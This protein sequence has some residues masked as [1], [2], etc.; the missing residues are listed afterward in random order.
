[1]VAGKSPVEE[2]VYISDGGDAL[3]PY[4]RDQLRSMWSSGLITA[5]TLYWKQ[6]SEEWRSVSELDLSGAKHVREK[7]QGTNAAGEVVKN[8]RSGKENYHKPYC[9]NCKQHVM[10]QVVG[11]TRTTGGLAVTPEGAPFSVGKLSSETSYRK[12]CPICGEEVFSKATL[13][14]ENRRRDLHTKET[15]RRNKSALLLLGGVWVTGVA[16]VLLGFVWGPLAI[17]FCAGSVWWARV[18]R[19]P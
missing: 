3:G 11:T 2:P 5:A 17:A 19:K 9:S 16:I 13:D 14:A 6:D 18:K 4:A 15:K 12:F 7:D 10:P 8:T 1:M